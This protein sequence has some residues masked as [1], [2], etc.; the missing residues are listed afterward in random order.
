MEL[1]AGAQVTDKLRLVREL[2]KGGMGSVWVADHLT[3]ERQVAVK[4]ISKEESAEAPLARQRF[5]R[6][7]K[8]AAKLDSPHVVHIYDHGFTAEG[9]PYIVMELLRGESLGARLKRGPLLPHQAVTVISQAAKALSAAHR[10]GI[11]HRDIKPDNIFLQDLDDE[12]FVKVLDFGVAKQMNAPEVKSVT[13]T[14]TV[15]G[16]PEFMSP[17]QLLGAKDIDF[18][19]DLWGL[20]V[21]AYRSLT[22]ALP[23]KGDSLIGLC[24]AITKGSP[25]P[26]SVLAGT[27][28]TTFDDWFEQ[29]LARDITTR[30][31]SAKQLARSFA[32]LCRDH[33]QST[34]EVAVD[35]SID[36]VP[37]SN[38]E[39]FA[40]DESERA[41]ETAVYVPSKGDAERESS[42]AV[43][44][45][46]PPDSS[47][48]SDDALAEQEQTTAPQTTATRANASVD[49]VASDPT[50][51]DLEKT[52]PAGT[53][54]T[55]VEPPV[56]RRSS[57]AVVYV[58]A[59]V[60][61]LAA[62]FAVGWLG[63][64]AGSGGADERGSASS[65]KTERAAVTTGAS[66]A[67][68]ESKTTNAGSVVSSEAAKP[69]ATVAAKVDDSPTK[70]DIT[71]SHPTSLGKSDATPSATARSKPKKTGSSV[72]ALRAALLG[73]WGR[74]E[75]G[76]PGQGSV[77]VSFSVRANS[78]GYPFSVG[79]VAPPP[80]FRNC[81]RGVI[82]SI[83]YLP[84]EKIKLSLTLPANTATK[85]ATT[86][87]A[88]KPAAT[89]SATSPAST[90]SK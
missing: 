63:G 46:T 82:R 83:T 26:P 22:G 89:T 15:V 42:G 17:E 49:V 9:V 45:L 90:A 18:R 53:K 13:V 10:L 34:D 71:K 56:D 19:A 27:L 50:L 68:A 2:G 78:R 86:V 20:A 37:E 40:A 64:L 11:V 66:K 72:G 8:A 6:E 39:A 67:L 38:E 75:G 30:F 70:S 51:G 80:K 4:F 21:V 31:T 54:P 43:A 41:A 79:M 14:G 58:L 87:S 28:G 36:E 60:G 35:E 61:A 3:L 76:E 69:S 33:V 48:L 81:A 23:F 52:L 16:T 59:G 1:T 88:A 12:L 55:L 29:A 85:P 73:C 47:A 62:V 44:A 84:E 65:A 32:G 25:T 57:R 74:T 5:E 24:L 77:Q 7:A